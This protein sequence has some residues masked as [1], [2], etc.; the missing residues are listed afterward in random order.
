M[1]CRGPRLIQVT[2]HL[3]LL[4][5]RCGTCC[6]LCYVW[7]II[8]CTALYYRLNAHVWMMSQNLVTSLFVGFAYKSYFLFT[9]CIVLATF[10]KTNPVAQYVYAKIKCC[11]CCTQ[12]L[13]YSHFV[14]P[15]YQPPSNRWD[16]FQQ[17]R[18]CHSEGFCGQY[19]E[20]TEDRISSLQSL[21]NSPTGHPRTCWAIA[22]QLN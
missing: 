12:Q 9:D 15:D 20:I 13:C 3:L 2:G 19:L 18:R 4:V 11:N 21:W 17:V 1:L 10:H 5:H 6:L 7:L 22:Y 14:W 16:T 8:I